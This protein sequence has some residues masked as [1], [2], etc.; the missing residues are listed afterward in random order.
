MSPMR[1]TVTIRGRGSGWFIRSRPEGR[2]WHIELDRGKCLVL[3]DRFRGVR[4]RDEFRKG[5]ESGM[6]VCS[7]CLREFQLTREG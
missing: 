4:G 2:V 1:V 7:Y 3:C 5:H 6:R